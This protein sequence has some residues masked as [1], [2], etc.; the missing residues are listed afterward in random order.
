MAIFARV[1][2]I[3]RLANPIHAVLDGVSGLRRIKAVSCLA[4][5]L[6][7]SFLDDP[8]GGYHWAS[9]ITWRATFGPGTI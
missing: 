2:H 8:N 3:R 4:G 1:R 9:R 6:C 7:L 5:V